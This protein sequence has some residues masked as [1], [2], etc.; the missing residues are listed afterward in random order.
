MAR[1]GSLFVLPVVRLDLA[2]TRARVTR[3]TS[4]SLHNLLATLGGRQLGTLLAWVC[5]LSVFAFGQNDG[6]STF[7]VIEDHGVDAIN[8]QNLDVLINPPVRGK[9]GAFPF[10]FA[11]VGNS[12]CDKKVTNAYSQNDVGVTIGPAPAGENAKSI[13]A[14]YDGLGR[15]KSLCEILSSGGSSC[16]Q[17]TAAAGYLT[18]YAY[19][20]FSGGT[21]STAT[22]G[23]QTRTSVYDAPKLV[24]GSIRK[25]PRRSRPRST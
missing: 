11:L 20:T 13:Q 25:T 19:S 23:V 21:K 3:K 12:N 6:I 10:H 2:R 17:N 1:F 5:L 4:H 24:Q 22:R 8:L 14:E 9:A 7:A 15:P 18:S 16:G